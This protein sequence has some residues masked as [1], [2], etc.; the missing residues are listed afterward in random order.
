MAETS[1]KIVATIVPP[2]AE[3]VVSRAQLEE[4]VSELVIVKGRL[5]EVMN[6]LRQM[7]RAQEECESYVR[8]AVKRIDATAGRL[9]KERAQLPRV[10]G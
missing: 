4:L 10:R 5:A 1:S 6:D 7:E 9:A 3:L 8:R 2:A